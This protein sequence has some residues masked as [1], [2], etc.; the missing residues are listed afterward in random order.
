MVFAQYQLRPWPP[1]CQLIPFGPGKLRGCV[2]SRR[3]TLSSPRRA[4]WL[5]H[6]LLSSSHCAVLSSTCRA[7]LLSHCLSLSSHCAALSSSCR[8][9]WLSHSLLP[10]SHCATLLSTHCTCTSL[11]SHR[12]SLS[13]RYAPRRPLVLSS[14]QLVVVSPLDAPPSRRLVVLSSRRA[15]S[16]CL[17]TPLVVAPSSLV[18]LSLHRPLVLSSCWLVVA[19]HVLAPPSC[20]LVCDHALRVCHQHIICQIETSTFRIRTLPSNRS[21]RTK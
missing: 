12:L 9:S 16:R 17:V 6:S 1:P 8:A 10:S 15:V 4:S 2:T 11:L 20:P 14:R 5:S 13:S 3:A 18:V 7:S 19:L 21:H